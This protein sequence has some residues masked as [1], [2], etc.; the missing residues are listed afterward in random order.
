MHTVQVALFSQNIIQNTIIYKLPGPPCPQW[1][2]GPCIHRLSVGTLYHI[3]YMHDMDPLSAST[4]LIRGQVYA[5]VR[6]LLSCAHS[7]SFLSCH[8]ILIS[9]KSYT[10]RSYSCSIHYSQN[11]IVIIL[12]FLVVGTK[13]GCAC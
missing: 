13:I 11:L 12:G 4:H 5:Q 1:W 2:L 9:L 7:A 3:Q 8:E 10:E 6:H